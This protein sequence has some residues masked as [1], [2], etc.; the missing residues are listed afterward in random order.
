MLEQLQ[1]AA[2]KLAHLCD[3]T[4]TDVYWIVS[5]DIG[6]GTDFILIEC[7]NKEEC[8]AHLPALRNSFPDV[9]FKISKMKQE[10]EFNSSILEEEVHHPVWL[11]HVK[12]L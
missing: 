4:N 5:A 12:Q 3:Y 10:E 11:D 2:D 9:S 6:F 7:N 8:E 1:N